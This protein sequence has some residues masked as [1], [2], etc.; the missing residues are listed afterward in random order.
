MPDKQPYAAFELPVWDSAAQQRGG[1]NAE[2]LA[3]LAAQR[4]AQWAA[5]LP[6]APIARVGICGAGIMGAGI[7][8]ANV[9]HGIAVQ[10]YDAA[11]T[12]VDRAVMV[13]RSEMQRMRGGPTLNGVPLQPAADL[14]AAC[15]Y[16]DDLSKAD[17]V[18]ESVVENRE[19]K[20]R[21][22]SQLA[23]GLAPAGIL[24]T[25]TSTIRINSLAA[26]LPDPSR[27][28]GLH[29]CNP[30]AHRR[31]V[32]IVCGEQT[33][34]TTLAAAVQYVVQIGKLPIVV[35]DS[36]GFLV[37]RLLLP[38]LNEALEMV[39]Q[40]AQLLHIDEAARQ[41]GMANGP[42][43]LF[44]L[45]GIDTAMWAGRTLWEAF[46]DR[47]A[48]TPVLPALVKRGRLGQKSGRGFYRYATPESP[49]QFDDELLPILAP[50]LRRTQRFTSEEIT[51]RLFLPMLVEATRAIEDGV[52]SDVRDVDVG[53]LF[54][55]AFPPSR[56]GLLFW[57]DSLGAATVVDLLQQ[58]AP[59]GKRMYPTQLLQSLALSGATFYN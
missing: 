53:T 23:T 27:F 22:L 29:F 41:F 3:T 42:I 48:L 46:P 26:S 17:L 24:A 45:I 57:A 31:L 56:G 52:V 9:K 51:L 49:G 58:L 7:A 21:I 54:G 55:L 14:L 37:N 47:T 32:E 16:L 36:P 25:N 30:V 28:C 44:D 6:P 1:R 43:E 18:I 13:I 39:C 15:R 59:L 35:R 50:Y 12:A 40:G 5:D 2:R 19:V 8:A 33:S 10:I 34:A 38:Y 4:P 20:Q 11:T